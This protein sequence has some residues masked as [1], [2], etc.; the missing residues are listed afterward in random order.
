M[1]KTMDNIVDLI[2]RAAW[3]LVRINKGD[4]EQRQV[5]KDEIETYA[6][7]LVQIAIMKADQEFR[8][9]SH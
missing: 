9:E 1:K 5:I 2:D 7:V 8:D 3:Q 6:S 4:T